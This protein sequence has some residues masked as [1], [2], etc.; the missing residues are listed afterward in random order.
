MKNNF[1]IPHNF[2]ETQAKKGNQKWLDLHILL[3][4]NETT[5][6]SNIFMKITPLKHS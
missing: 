3:V 5:P 6:F 1:L 2:K 4:D